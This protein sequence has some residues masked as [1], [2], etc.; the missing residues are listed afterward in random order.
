MRGFAT[1]KVQTGREHDVST[2]ECLTTLNLFAQISIANDPSS[3]S[4]LSTRFVQSGDDSDD[5]ALLNVGHGSDGGEVSSLSPFVHHRYQCYLV[6]RCK[7][8]TS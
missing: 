3:I 4:D 8:F 5:R 7:V 1:L 2:N 6:R